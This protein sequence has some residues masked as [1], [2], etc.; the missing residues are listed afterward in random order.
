[1]IKTDD[2]ISELEQF[3]EQIQDTIKEE[4]ECSLDEEAIYREAKEEFSDQIAERY[5]E[6]SETSADQSEELYQEACEEF[7]DQIED[8]FMELLDERRSEF[9]DEIETDIRDSFEEDILATIRARQ[10]A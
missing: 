6:L 7:S 1:M 9:E 3:E 10:N 2:Q 8:R 5:D 4:L